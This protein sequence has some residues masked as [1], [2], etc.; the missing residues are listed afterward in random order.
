LTSENVDRTLTSIGA[1]DIK[2]TKT[3]SA[4]H[5]RG[6]AEHTGGTSFEAFTAVMI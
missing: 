1:A 5:I 4:W 3:F 6:T 2:T